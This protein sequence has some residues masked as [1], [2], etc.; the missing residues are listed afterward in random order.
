MFRC[1]FAIAFLIFSL[2]FVVSSAQ[3]PQVNSVSPDSIQ[4]GTEAELIVSGDNLDGLVRVDVHGGE[5]LEFS[6]VADPTPPEKRDP[7]TK[8]K[9]AKIKVRATPVAGAG[10][11]ELRFI[12]PGGA[13]NPVAFNVGLYPLVQ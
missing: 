1:H 5:G 4:R 8:G 12:A 10:D 9:S 2:S 11:R 13:S 6:I 3:P 7:K